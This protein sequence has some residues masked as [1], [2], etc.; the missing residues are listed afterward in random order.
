M[1]FVPGTAMIGMLASYTC[2]IF[3]LDPT[4]SVPIEPLA[5]VIPGVTPFRATLDAITTDELMKTYTITRHAI[6]A[7]VD[8][9]THRKRD[10][11][12]LSVSGVISAAPPFSLV[13]APAPP[14]F[15]FRLDLLRLSM[16]QR[17]AD[18]HEPVMV[19][20][21]RHSLALA[22]IVSLR[23]PWTPAAGRS[24]PI[25]LQFLECRIASPSLTAAIKD[26]DQLEP[27]NT[28]ATSG[29]EQAGTEVN[30]D[31]TPGE[32]SQLAPTVGAA[33]RT[34]A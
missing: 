33:N 16:L 24:T 6:Q 1:S 31:S 12:R 28:S 3:R 4:G 29:G 15:G 21:P 2:S 18:R 22:W 25:A 34:A 17:I 5:D 23:S 7:L 9:T 11:Q 30:A 27:G 32:T 19:I 14:T 20:T 8:V 26:L 10:L 13:N